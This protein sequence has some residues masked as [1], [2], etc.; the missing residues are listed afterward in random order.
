MT[1]TQLGPYRIERRLAIGGMA[2]VFVARREGPHGFHKRVALKRILPHL[3]RDA[4]FVSMFIDEAKL[5][6][7]L[8]H[9]NVVQV[10]DF[11]EID[12][13]L[14]LAMEYVEGASVARLLRAADFYD[15][16]V[17]LDIALYI[18]E[19]SAR[20]LAHLHTLQDDAG[21]PLA[22]VHR[23]VS[24]A[25]LLLTRAGHIKVTDFGIAAIAGRDAHTEAG[26]VRGKLGYMSPEQVMALPL[27]DRSDV[28]ALAAILAEMLIG[29][30]LFGTG[31][32]L[33]VLVRIR[34]VDLAHLQACK[35]PIPA[36]VRA[37]LS[38]KL[39]EFSHV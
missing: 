11:G 29:R 16:A 22:V 21:K 8:E 32:D 14:F 33:D 26:H 10:F 24:P 19:Q 28:F 17:P 37:L 36:D 9:P 31:S 12:G 30:T 6:A 39:E 27:D 23:D 2:E 7:Q 35:R 18:A 20:G 5:A 34:D 15:E 1:L 3:A 4:E 38:P 13:E 25:N